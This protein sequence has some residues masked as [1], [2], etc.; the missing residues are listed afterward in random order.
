MKILWHGYD[1]IIDARSPS[2]Y[3]IDCIPNAINLPALFDNE[4]AEIGILHK[5]SP[6]AA[7]LR[8]AGIVATNIAT[9]LQEHL[10]SRPQH[11][12]PL[13]YC[14]RGGQRSASVT[15]VLRQI[16]WDATRLAGGYKFYRQQVIMGLDELPATL[17]WRV[18]G[19]KTGTGKTPLLTHLQKLGHAV[20]DLEGLANHRGS[21]FGRMGE[22]PSQRKFESQ[23]FAA[24]LSMP[25][26]STV[27][28]ESESRKIGNLHVPAKVLSAMRGA[29][30]FYLQANI[31]DR[32]CRI[33]NDYENMKS[34]EYFNTALE[35]IKK[36]VGASR[37]RKWREYHHNQQ[38]EVLVSDML[39]TFYDI[40]YEK[41]LSQRDYLSRQVF[42][43]NPNCEN[44]MREA[45]GRIVKA[46]GV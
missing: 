14:W 46:A 39:K 3:A 12:K 9:H 1:E 13:V 28:V 19:G 38:W 44:S 23:L 30:A 15:E 41:S 21:T 6:F 36:Y 42:D 5:T 17:S 10:A 18:I 7:R 31:K 22:Q 37:Y 40:G 33:M 29:P 32:V 16:G 20:I 11:W 25:S 4:R 24:L 45:A 2:E 43:I 35:D 26:Q 8:G 27:F 34:A